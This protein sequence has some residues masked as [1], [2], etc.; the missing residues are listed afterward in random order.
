MSN[1]QDDED[2]RNDGLE[3]ER[4]FNRSELKRA[5]MQSDDA[6]TS[7]SEGLS[8]IDKFQI[9]GAEDNPSIGSTRTFQRGEAIKGDTTLKPKK[10]KEDSFTSFSDDLPSVQQFTILDEERRIDSGHLQLL[11][12]YLKTTDCRYLKNYESN[13][14]KSKTLDRLI[15]LIETV[16]WKNEILVDISHSPA[17]HEYRFNEDTIVLD[18]SRSDEETLLDFAHQ[19]YH[20]TNRLLTKLYDGELLDQYTYIDLLIWSEVA[21]LITE[22]NVRRDF[23]ITKVI[24]SMVLCQERAGTLS[25]INVEEFMKNKGMKSL[26]DELVY[27]L[28]RGSSNTTLLDVLN[29][30][31][32]SYR[33][34]YNEYATES[35]AVIEHCL[36]LGL[37]RDCI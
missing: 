24:P 9:L 27:S 2:K 5:K 32:E 23:G 13:K 25:S 31:Y 6:F 1:K 17:S 15:H 12:D 11:S 36:A 20:A 7:F 28:V 18:N 16:P 10:S 34:T 35:S 14:G 4:V 21:A 3:K 26:H 22:L 37:E 33:E 30:L 19:T 8:T 29:E